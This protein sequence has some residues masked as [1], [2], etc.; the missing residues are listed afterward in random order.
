METIGYR[1]DWTNSVKQWTLDAQALGYGSS[2]L[3]FEK[4]IPAII[5]TGSSNIEIPEGT[6]K[7]LK[8]LWKKDVPDLDCV[9][10]D[11]FCQVMTPCNEISKKVKPISLQISG[12]VF[13]L[14]PNLYL[15]QAEGKRCQFAIHSNE[16]KGSSANLML[17]G[18]ILLRHLY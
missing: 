5:D 13:E 12:S 8:E 6:Y 17:V 10:D 11:N 2:D 14:Q 15:H 7:Q 1:P 9:I 4:N 16:L 18:D 3:I